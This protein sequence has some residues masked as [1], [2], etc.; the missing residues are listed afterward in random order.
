MSRYNRL[1]RPIAVVGSRAAYMHL[2]H[3]CK[4][5]PNGNDVF[6]H[7]HDYDTATAGEFCRLLEIDGAEDVRDYRQ[8]VSLVRTR[9][10]N[11]A[12]ATKFDPRAAHAD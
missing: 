3:H 10:R 1:S 9:V 6:F 5:D 11:E 7:V 8:I 2:C 12:R 4:V